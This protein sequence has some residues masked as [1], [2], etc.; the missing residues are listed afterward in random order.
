M[1]FGG[2]MT[3]R[4]CEIVDCGAFCEVIFFCISRKNPLGDF[5]DSHGRSPQLN[6][7]F[8]LSA[9][10]WGV[11]PTSQRKQTMIKLDD[12]DLKVSIISTAKN[13]LGH[14]SI[15]AVSLTRQVTF[16]FIFSLRYSRYKSFLLFGTLFPRTVKKVPHILD[17]FS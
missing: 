1:I 13:I 2:L 6:E 8:G 12:Y 3:L 9:R 7:N 11:A 5:F 14:F 15:T 10:F 17:F 16:L 4:N